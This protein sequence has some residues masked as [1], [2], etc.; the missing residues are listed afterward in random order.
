MTLRENVTR[1]IAFATIPVCVS[2]PSWSSRSCSPAAAAPRSHGPVRRGAA[3]RWRRTPGADEAGVYFATAARLRHAEG[4]ELRARTL[5]QRRLP[6]RRATRRTGCVAVLAIVRPGQARA[7]RGRG[8]PAGR[9]RQGRGRRARAARAATRRRSCEP[10]EAVGAM[11]EQVPELDRDELSTQ[12]DAAA[13][14][15]TAGA[16][17]FGEL[18]PGPG[19]DPSVARVT[20]SALLSPDAPELLAH[21]L[22]PAPHLHG[23]HAALAQLAQDQLAGDPGVVEQ[24]AACRVTVSARR[25]VAELVRDVE[26]EVPVVVRVRLRVAASRA[27]ARRR[28]SGL[29]WTR[30]SSSRSVQSDGSAS[31]ISWNSSASGMICR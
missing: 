15:W 23:L 1:R 9:A 18:A 5:G 25:R 7:V 14:T 27:A 12:L 6:A 3:R 17:Y 22:R 8:D 4:V 19:R 16:Q 10:D 29:S 24:A 13:A 20:P 21:G 26:V 2:R 28:C 30:R 31:R 11:V